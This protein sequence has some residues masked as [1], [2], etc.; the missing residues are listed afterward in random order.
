MMRTM[1]NSTLFESNSDLPGLL[2]D[3]IFSAMKE[4]N[5]P[6]MK[7]SAA[8]T[9]QRIKMSTIASYR[10]LA[11]SFRTRMDV[12]IMSAMNTMID[13]A[14]K[15]WELKRMIDQYKNLRRS[16]LAAQTEEEVQKIK[17]DEKKLVANRE[18]LQLS[19]APYFP[20]DVVTCYIRGLESPGAW[21]SELLMLHRSV[22]HFM[23]MAR[24]QCY[25]HCCAGTG[26]CANPVYARESHEH[27]TAIRYI[28]AN[29]GNQM[30]TCLFSKPNCVNHFTLSLSDVSSSNPTYEG[31]LAIDMLR[32]RGK[33]AADLQSRYTA[34][35]FHSISGDI[36][37]LH[38]AKFVRNIADI[39]VPSAQKDLSISRDELALSIQELARK[40]KQKEERK[41]MITE[42]DHKFMMEDVDTTLKTDSAYGFS[43][44]ADMKTTLPAI[45]AAL[46]W[47]I[48]T[49][50]V[51]KTMAHAMDVLMVA[52]TMHELRM[53]MGPIRKYDAATYREDMASTE[54]YDFVSGKSS[55]VI[56]ATSKS[57]SV[58]D[59]G[60]SAIRCGVGSL[61]D[62]KAHIDTNY[63]HY[64]IGVVCAAMRLF[65]KLADWK[66]VQEVGEEA[67][68]KL[69]YLAHTIKN[70]EGTFQARLMINESH[71]ADVCSRR[72]SE[73]VN[74][75]YALAEYKKID[76][77]LPSSKL[78]GGRDTMD[79]KHKWF[80]QMFKAM[81]SEPEMRFAALTMAG[82]G[83][84]ELCDTVIC[85]E[86]QRYF[87]KAGYVF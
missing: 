23:A 54:A 80:V 87:C 26:R 28:D 81:F 38:N 84:R 67:S 30:T 60:W 29:T 9:R 40:D 79:K 22:A 21:A 50:H 46:E 5:W 20:S 41:R 55:A 13:T 86:N 16:S 10:L 69:F 33:S 53:L 11:K 75:I 19:M 15:F 85:K 48:K 25:L 57:S 2:C 62:K 70:G 66:V 4:D 61:L 56:C 47:A 35:V 74:A 63:S 18:D 77:E 65:D 14:F 27:F 37:A 68:T 76:I 39:A 73:W 72:R 83:P 71:A 49:F 6:V 45:G 7:D 31:R 82:I 64:T 24:Q 36:H 12:H 44:M 17:D 32:R 1:K 58:I 8:S 78:D 43:S 34:P 51:K 59:F 52:S 3:A 42:I